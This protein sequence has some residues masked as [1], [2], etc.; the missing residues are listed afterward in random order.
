MEVKEVVQGL[1]PKVI[2]TNE[3]FILTK[4]EQEQV[5]FNAIENAKKHK[6]WKLANRGFNE[7][8]IWLKLSEI[9]FSKEINEAEILRIAN[10]N[11]H[12]AI[13]QRR[14]FEKYVEEQRKEKEALINKCSAKYMFR[15]MSFTSKNVFGKKLMVNNDN[16]FLIKALCFYLSRDDRFEKEL[17]LSLDKGLIIR[18]STGLGKTHL[19]KCLSGNELNPI[20]CINTISVTKE[21]KDEGEY[22][23]DLG[24]NKILFIDDFGSEEPVVNVFGT[25]ISFFRDLLESYYF[26]KKSYN[27]LIIST[28][29]NNTDIENIYGKRVRSRNDEMFNIIT[30]SGKDMR[31][32]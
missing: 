29:L 20:L 18:G 30:V 32:Q 27:N 26:N 10:S 2:T 21:L 12:R 19:V 16:S 5:L 28:N 17:G 6:T 8:S 13:E 23:I 24:E 9:D 7:N 3:D 14:Q 11:K 4:E 1:F 22:H 15:L 31:K 25:K